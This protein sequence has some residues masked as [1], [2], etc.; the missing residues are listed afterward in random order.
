[1]LIP[2]GILNSGS[3]LE[4]AWDLLAST[5][6]STAGTFS[7]TSLPQTHK[8]LVIYSS[9]TGST[10][11]S[12]QPRLIFNNITTATY[13]SQMSYGTGSAFTTN[14]ESA[15]KGITIGQV[16]DGTP[17]GFAGWTIVPDYTGSKHK[18][19]ISN[20]STRLDNRVGVFFGTSS[21]TAA[22]TEIQIQDDLTAL[23]AAGSRVSIYGV[24]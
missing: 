9:L 15:T 8:H 17:G 2:L 23:F 19:A 16:A 6:L 3:Q 4:N 1:M 10:T 24:K 14:A 5:Q 20:S 22:I 18:V 12:V 21:Q 11:T 13:D 7:F